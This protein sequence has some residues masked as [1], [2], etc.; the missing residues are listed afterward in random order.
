MSDGTEVLPPAAVDQYDVQ[1]LMEAAAEAG[2]ALK[3]RQIWI[4]EHP[5]YGWRPGTPFDEDVARWTQ[6][7][8]ERL[9]AYIDKRIENMKGREE[10]KR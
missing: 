7:F 8:G 1:E 5:G 6:V 2:Y 4:S 10:Q 9:N 3:K